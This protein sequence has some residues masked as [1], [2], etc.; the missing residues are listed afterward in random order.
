MPQPR[1]PFQPHRPG[2]P[3]STPQQALALT[4][5]I[6]GALIVGLLAFGTVIALM[7]DGSGRGEYPQLD[8]NLLLVVAV[9]L[10]VVT[11]I[12]TAFVRPTAPSETTPAEIRRFLSSFVTTKV[13]CSALVEGPG[14]FWIVLAF[15]SGDRMFLLGGAFAIILL[16]RELPSETQIENASGLERAEIEAILDAEGAAPS[17]I[18]NPGASE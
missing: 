5:I 6:V 9:V 13:I 1:Q 2:P 7:A 8:P 11:T 4:R 18:G 16:L 3:V 14:L 10:T 17:R 15:L 12:G